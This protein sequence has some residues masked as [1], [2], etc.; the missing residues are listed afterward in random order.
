[1]TTEELI[2]DEVLERIQD[3]LQVVLARPYQYPQ[4]VDENPP[5]AVSI[6]TF[7]ILQCLDILGTNSY[8]LI[9]VGTALGAQLQ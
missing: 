2:E 1:M 3:I 4:L 5:T 7:V 6:L 9:I 8:R